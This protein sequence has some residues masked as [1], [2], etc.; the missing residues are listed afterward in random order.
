[1][2]AMNASRRPS[3]RAPGY[4][5]GADRQVGNLLPLLELALAL[6]QHLELVADE[7]EHGGGLGRQDA[8]IQDEIQPVAEQVPDVLGV[9]ERLAL[10]VRRRGG[11][12]R[13]AQP[14]GERAR[15]GRVRDAD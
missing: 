7:A 10:A 6:A 13:M 12:E 1:M 14:G 2:K 8:A 5:S 3:M 4:W 11:D 9:D 15:E